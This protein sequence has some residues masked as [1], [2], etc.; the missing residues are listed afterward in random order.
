MASTNTTSDGDD[1]TTIG[2]W[3]LLG[4]GGIVSLCCLFATPAATGAAGATVSGGTT[5]AM[6]GG[7]VRVLV[8]A[9]T[10]GLVGL[11]VRYR[12]DTDCSCEA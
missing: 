4:L 11:V 7:L 9:L 10:V 8:T 3:P 1:E 5:A 6:G 12:L 2:R